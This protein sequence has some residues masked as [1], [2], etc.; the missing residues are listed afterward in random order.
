M[1]LA[2]VVGDTW[3]EGGVGGWPWSG[4]GCPAPGEQESEPAR[5]PAG[6]APASSRPLEAG[7]R[8]SAKPQGSGVLGQT[9]SHRLGLLSLAL[10]QVGKKLHWISQ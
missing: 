8:L 10:R 9:R 3:R 5:A 7:S 1:P 2:V 4:T 6:S